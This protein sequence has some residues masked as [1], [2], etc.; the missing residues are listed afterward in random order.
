MKKRSYS[1]LRLGLTSGLLLTVFM[2]QGNVFYAQTIPSSEPTKAQ[3]TSVH[4]LDGQKPKKEPEK[5]LTKVIV[6]KKKQVLP[7]KEDKQ[8]QSEFNTP[9]VSYTHLTLPTN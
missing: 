2:S 9:P 7:K 5:Q 3:V 1:L 8:I 4:S 6:N